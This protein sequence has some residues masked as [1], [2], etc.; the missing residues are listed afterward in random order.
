[1]I[2]KRSVLILLLG[3]VLLLVSVKTVL[4]TVYINEIVPDVGTID[5][6]TNGAVSESNDEWVELYNN[7]ADEDISGWSISDVDNN[8]Y[9]FTAGTNFPANSYLTVFDL[10][11][12]NSGDTVTLYDVLNN[13]VDVNSWTT[14]PGNDISLSRIHDGSSTWT[15]ISAPTINTINNRLPTGSLPAQNF[16]EDAAAFFVPLSTITD[17]DSDALSF[18]V[19]SENTAQADCTISGN[20]VLVDSANNYNGAAS[21]TIRA[22]DSFGTTDFTMSMTINAIDDPAVWNALTAKNVNEDS[23]SGTVVYPNLKTLCTDVDTAITMSVTST[24]T[25]Y[26]LSFSGNN[27]NIS[28]L[29]QNWNGL[30]TVNLNCNGIPSSF[31]LTINPVN[32]PAVVTAIPYQEADESQEYSYTITATDVDNTQAQLSLVSA[33]L[34][35]WLQS[36]SVYP[37]LRGTPGSADSGEN[38]TVTVMVNDGSVNSAPVLF[39]LFIQP[40]LEIKA[41]DVQ[42][43]IDGTTYGADDQLNVTPGSEVT[44]TYTLTNNYIESLGHVESSAAANVALTGLPYTG[45]CVGTDCNNGYWSILPGGEGSSQFTFTVPYNIGSSTFSLTLNTNYD[46]FWLPIL[47]NNFVNSLSLNLN[48]V[49]ENVSAY[50]LQSDL[51]D[52]NLTCTRTAE[53]D[54]EVANAG[55]LALTPEIL[56]YD[57]QPTESSFSSTTGEFTDFGGQ[58]PVIRSETTLSS[59]ASGTSASVQIPVD[60]LNLT[61]GTHTLYIY[62]VN[63]Y[64]DSSGYYIGDKTEVTITIGSCF[65][66]SALEQDLQI[67]KSSPAGM[68]VDLQ[69]YILEDTLGYT[70]TFA[71][72]DESNTA[73]VDC[74]VAGST[75]TCPAPTAGTQGTSD[76]TIAVDETN[77]LTP[78]EEV[79]TVT[80]TPT[81]E[82]SN[83]RVNTIAVTENSLTQALKPQQTVTVQLTAT[84]VLTH[85]VTGVSA[86]LIVPTLPAI[87]WSSSAVNLVAG[88]SKTL[89]ITS[90][91]PLDVAE[92]DYPVELKISGRDYENNLVQQSDSYIFILHVDQEAADLVITNFTFGANTVTCSDST[93]VTVEYTNRGSQ[94]ESDAS[95]TLSGRNFVSTT[96]LA[97]VAPNTFSSIIVDVPTSNLTTGANTLTATLTYRDSFKSDIKTSSITKNNCLNS[98]IPTDSNLIVADGVPQV[99]T[100]NLSESGYDSGIS[101]YVD[102]ALVASTINTYTFTQSTVGTYHLKAVVNDNEADAHTWTV[103]VTNIPLSAA[104]TTNIPADATD[105]ELSNFHNFTVQNSYG[106]IVFTE[107]VD[108]TNIFDLDEIITISNAMVFV[109]TV[110]APELAGKSAEITLQR[111]FTQP[112]ILR[113]T[114]GT[115]FTEECPTTTCQTASN[116]DGKFVFTVN[117]FSAYQVVEEIPAGIEISE[118]LFNNAV[119]GENASVTITVR[120][121][122]TFESLTGLSAQLAGVS[123]VYLPVLEGTLP[124]TLAA[125]Q[126]ATVTLKINVPAGEDGGRHSIGTVQVNSNQETKIQTIYLLP[127]SF[128]TL[129]SIKVEGKTTG[130]FTVDGDNEVRVKV[131]NDYTED[132]ED[133]IV[134]VTLFDVDGDDLE[135][136]SDSFDLDTGDTKEVTLNFNVENADNEEIEMEILV[137]GTAT[138]DSSHETKETRTFTVAREKH[139]VILQSLSASAKDL[140]CSRLTTISAT[141][142]NVG[143][144]DEDTVEVKVSNSALGIE[145]SKSDIEVDKYS[146]SDN[147]Y[148]ARFNLDLSKAA[149]GTYTIPIEVYLDGSLEDSQDLTLTVKN[150]LTTSDSSQSQSV[151][152]DALKQKMEQQLQEAL[153]TP[154]AKPKVSSSFRDSN[155]YLALLGVLALLMFVALV[156]ALAVMLKGK[157]AKQ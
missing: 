144:S 103:T 153:K 60:A 32:D 137:E 129:E 29:E 134:T 127:K 148:K 17:A 84:N 72:S 105:A 82:V 124:T 152:S 25:H 16:N 149:A 128:L 15:N 142:E 6:D 45:T 11:L 88:E 77:A 66:I 52:E 102:D 39:N 108:L 1:M 123:S 2:H 64:F 135:E 71:L 98:W 119:A 5:W 68:S 62:M 114:D 34:P 111:S 73:L 24:H 79:A 97:D 63:P 113:S 141:V 74:S 139:K 37:N 61:S 7:G 101:W 20:N 133:I 157:K 54:M 121:K 91:L 146:D 51:T 57:M 93:A 132:M 94:T 155:T 28:N 145:E 92:G 86:E 44:V 117:S 30:E 9:T 106:K 12:S 14:N 55:S 40:A 42:V 43:V 154:A 87:D 58:T 100:L 95:I 70:F 33:S 10:S 80:I 38:Q 156:L 118:I 140:E 4:G 81:L 109:N 83:V 122:G 46:Q 22:N 26:T 53:V 69:N 143:K 67:P 120:N 75:L 36:D 65:N 138:D 99:F 19:Q 41:S 131:K 126:Q 115:T 125:S 27:L 107:N 13:S 130:D 49:R 56:I 90:I 150:C 85:P 110:A 104:L 89:T 76:L 23:A 136:E 50:I 151:L 147:D 59:L 18:I 78:V 3:L 96:A 35:S 48:V 47:G 112:L 8:R 116:A 31:Q 21:C